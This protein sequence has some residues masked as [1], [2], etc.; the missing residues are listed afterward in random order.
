MESGEGKYLQHLPDVG[1]QSLK[2]QGCSPPQESLLTGGHGGRTAGKQQ[3]C[4]GYLAWHGGM[5]TSENHL[6]ELKKK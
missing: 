2:S 3:K 1:G 4:Q 6:Q 5:D